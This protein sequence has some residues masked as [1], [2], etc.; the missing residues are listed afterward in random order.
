[1][2]TAL[3]T[4]TCPAAPFT[5]SSDFERPSS[6]RILEITG[7]NTG[8]VAFVYACRKLLGPDVSEIPWSADPDY[9][10]STFDHIVVACANQLGPHVELSG[11]AAQIKA[12]DLPVTLLGLGAQSASQAAYPEIPAG[13][14]DFLR[15]VTTRNA[16]TAPNIAVRGSY[17]QSVLASIGV[18]SIPAGCPSLLISSVARLGAAIYSR[19]EATGIHRIAV[20]AGNPWHGPS[21]QLERKLVDLVDM[22]PGEYVLQHPQA[23]FRYALGEDVDTA[24][25]ERFLKV[26]GERFRHESLAAWFRRHSVYFLEAPLWM[27]YLDR[28]DLVVGPRYH[29]VALGIQMGI[30]GAV[31]SIDART[32]EL[33]ETTGVPCIRLEDA[34]SMR[35]EE[36]VLAAKWSPEQALHFDEKRRQAADNYRQLFADQGL[37]ISAHLASITAP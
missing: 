23:M 3:I 37:P 32:E 19:Q 16:G 1:M 18:D 5:S 22:W 33:A 25:Q 15:E 28:F 6:S 13:T 30:P 36:L 31:V 34:N 24:T 26:Y 12:F 29:G 35:P 20:A 27:R 10:R 14:L 8:N 4:N 9:V 2:R 7:G 17:T 11:W 21:A